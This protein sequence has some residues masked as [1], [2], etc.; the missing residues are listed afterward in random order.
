VEVG[1]LHPEFGQD[2]VLRPVVGRPDHRCRIIF[3][4]PRRGIIWI[5]WLELYS[6]WYQVSAGANVQQHHRGRHVAVICLAV[7]CGYV[8]QQRVVHQI[9]VSVLTDTNRQTDRRMSKHTHTDQLSLAIPLW[10]GAMSTST[11]DVF[12]CLN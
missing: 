1:V 7:H 3:I 6:Q 10:R 5:M 2:P 4:F 9:N 8:F 11:S 12:F